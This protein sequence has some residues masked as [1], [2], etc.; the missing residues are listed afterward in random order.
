MEVPIDKSTNQRK[1][2]CFVTFDDIAVSQELLKTPKQ[3]IGGKEV[4][5]ILLQPVIMLPVLRR[6]LLIQVDVK[7]AV[8]MAK[9]Q[10]GGWHDAPS[11]GRGG[12][13]R[14]GGMR[15]G[16]GGWGGGGYGGGGGYA[17]AYSSWGGGGP[18]G[19]GYAGGYDAYGGGYYDY[20]GYGYEPTPW[21]PR[22]RGGRGGFGGKMRGSR[23]IP[24][25][26]PY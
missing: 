18:Y 4:N 21:P 7:Q 13:G 11:G 25:Q 1:N 14:G 10:G 19:G 16:R 5:D 3:T 12:R 23:G 20:D 6:L 17:P 26:S 9:P 24:R 2:Y 15:G 22:G 8:P